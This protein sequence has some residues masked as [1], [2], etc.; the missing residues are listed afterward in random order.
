MHGPEC[1]PVY[2]PIDA[3]AD[4]V[5]ALRKIESMAGTAGSGETPALPLAKIARDALARLDG[6]A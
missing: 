4:A 2:A 3:L 1:P 6:E 5:E